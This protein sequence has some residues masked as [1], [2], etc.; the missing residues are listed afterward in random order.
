[1]T[2][3]TGASVNGSWRVVLDSGIANMA[4][5]EDRIRVSKDSFRS[6]DRKILVTTDLSSLVANTATV[7]DLTLANLRLRDVPVLVLPANP[8]LQRGIEDGLLPAS[9]FRC[10]LVNARQN[11]AIVDIED[12]EK[13]VIGSHAALTARTA[14]RLDPPGRAFA[15]LPFAKI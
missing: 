12:L 15:W 4:L 9:F 2:A 3:K 8:E 1:M 11:Y 7:R 6:R 5:F 13:G 14:K 10:I